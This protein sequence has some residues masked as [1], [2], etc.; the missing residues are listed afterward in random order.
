VIVLQ[1]FYKKDI[2]SLVGGQ[3][4]MEILWKQESEVADS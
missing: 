2:L 4:K 1:I 3:E